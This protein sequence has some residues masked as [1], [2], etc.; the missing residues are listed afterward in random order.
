[1]SVNGPC[2]SSK[3][4]SQDWCFHVT[5]SP[6]YPRPGGQSKRSVKPLKE[7]LEKSDDPYKALLSCRNTPLDRVN[8]SPAQM[9]TG[10][11]LRN[12]IPVTEEMLKP[13]LYEPEEVLPKLKERQRKQ[14]VHHGRTAKELP[15]LKNGEVVRQKE[16]SK[17]KWKPARVTHI[18]SSPR[19]YR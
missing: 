15:P 11:R 1:M 14:K 6:G 10:T 2:Y 4:F 13:Q 7:M 3:Q 18:L 9:L 19:S 12:F 17:L 16:G 8:L 5:S